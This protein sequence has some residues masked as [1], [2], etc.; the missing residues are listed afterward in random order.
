M[1]GVCCGICI[2]GGGLGWDTLFGMAWV[3]LLGN[4]CENN[5]SA[6]LEAV[7]GTGAASVVWVNHDVEAWL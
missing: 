6:G 1:A 2:L 5:H 7:Y 3:W 4:W